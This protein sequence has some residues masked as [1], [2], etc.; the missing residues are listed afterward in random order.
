MKRFQNIAM[1][2]FLAALI[3]F[4]GTVEAGG[5][6]FVPLLALAASVVMMAKTKLLNL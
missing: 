4:V 6:I 1:I 3:Y 2:M 5:S